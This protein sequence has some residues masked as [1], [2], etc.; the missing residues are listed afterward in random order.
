M[1]RL[2]PYRRKSSFMVLET[3]LPHEYL[4]LAFTC[5]SML[6][7]LSR[8]LDTHESYRLGSLGSHITRAVNMI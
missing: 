2:E 5:Q 1:I 6:S 4:G 3:M 8:K 7:I